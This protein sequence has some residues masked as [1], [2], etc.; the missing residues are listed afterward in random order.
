MIY[1][2][3]ITGKEYSS[4][5]E[6][7]AAEKEFQKQEEIRVAEEEKKVAESNKRK[8]ELAKAIEDAEAKLTEANRLYDIAQ[9]KAAKILE[10][11]NKEV[12]E[13]LN[14]A[15][16]EVDAAQK[17]RFEAI[18]AFNREFGSYTT[19]YTGAKAAEEFNRYTN[20]FEKR[21]RNLFNNFF[22][23]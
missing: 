7:L 16:A 3:E 10:D 20:N 13:I 15:E 14:T 4:E 17:A 11:S 12:K 23:F 8:K 19:K 2:S 18:L 22:L 9:D 21:L 6:C 1:K 5:K